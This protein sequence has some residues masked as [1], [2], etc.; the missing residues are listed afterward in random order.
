MI[1]VKNNNNNATSKKTLKWTIAQFFE[2]L[3]WKVWATPKNK[4]KYLIFVRKRWNY[5]LSKIKTNLNLQK[6]DVVL[7]AGCGPSGIFTILEDYNVTAID[8]LINK[9]EKHLDYFKS[10]KYEYVNF[11]KAPIEDFASKKKFK[12]VFCLNVI[13]HV[14]DINKATSELIENTSNNGY[15]VITV[16]VHKYKIIKK[17]FQKIQIPFDIWHPHQYDLKEYKDIF[18]NKKNVKLVEKTFIKHGGPL[19]KRIAFVLK[20]IP[21]K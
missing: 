4:E 8:P 21:T 9:Y 15:L 17:I 10:S 14:L 16:D 12:V 11:I 2:F 7:D 18:T 13:N 6:N 1:I 20:K 19:F 5:L 3:Y